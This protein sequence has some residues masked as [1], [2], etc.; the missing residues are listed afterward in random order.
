MKRIIGI[1]SIVGTMLF[2]VQGANAAVL[3][4]L[5]LSPGTLVDNTSHN[6]ILGST[7]VDDDVELFLTG[8]PKFLVTITATSSLG[9]N[10]GIP[11]ISL[12]LLDDTGAHLPVPGITTS[13]FANQFV[14]TFTIFTPVLLETGITPYIIHVSG[15]ARSGGA[16]YDLTAEASLVPIPAAA[17][18]FASGLGVLG[19]AGRRKR[20]SDTAAL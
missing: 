3:D 5:T 17:L 15:T 1:L 13:T 2:A 9:L 10:S 6:S 12:S 4:T 7:A 16:S 18:L 8:W 14:A 20:A 11:G 19:F